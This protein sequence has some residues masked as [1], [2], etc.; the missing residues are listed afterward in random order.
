MAHD[1]TELNTALAARIVELEA[2]LRDA[3]NFIECSAFNM[4]SPKGK[5]N[6]RA[7]ANRIAAAL[8]PTT[9]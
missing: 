6:Y 2:A 5:A 4:T 7:C 3:Q 1:A 9:R 8:K